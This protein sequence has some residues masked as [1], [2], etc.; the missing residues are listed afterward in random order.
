MDEV[1]DPGTD[2]VTQ[3]RIN[4][5]DGS[6]VGIVTPVE[7]QAVNQTLTHVFLNEAISTSGSRWWMRTAPTR[8]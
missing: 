1:I 4:W 8:T 3:Y 7:L 6:P 2:S 5:G